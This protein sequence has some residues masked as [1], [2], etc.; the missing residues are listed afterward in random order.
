MR[1]ISVRG[2]SEHNLKHIDLDIPH[3]SLSVI[4]GL[5][6][7]GK[8]SLAFDTIF[9]EGQRRYVESLSAYARQFLGQM[10]RPHV[11]H[12]EGLAPAAAIDQRAISRNS[13]S[14]VGTITE[15]SD[16]LRLL[17]ARIGHVHCHRCGTPIEPQIADNIVDRILEL[18]HG[19][20]ATVL[21]PV[22]RHRKGEHREL[23]ARLRSTGYVRARIDGEMQ[24]LELAPQLARTK[25]HDIEVAVDRVKIGTSTRER[26]TDSVETALGLA[27]GLLIVATEEGDHLFSSSFGCP[28]CGASVEPPEPA[29]FS[30]NSRRGGCPNCKGLGRVLDF[31]PDNLIRDRRLSIREGAISLTNKSGYTLYAQMPMT[32]WKQ[33]G[34][35]FNFDIDIPWAELSEESRELIL[36]GA[37]RK[38]FTET[39]TWSEDDGASQGTRTQ[40]RR[41]QGLI[42]LL[43][44]RGKSGDGLAEWVEDLMSNQVCPDCN[45]ARLREEALA[46]TFNDKSI[47]EVT[48]LSIAAARDFM[49]GSVMSEREAIIATQIRREIDL[50][51]EFLEKV[52]LGYLTLGRGADTLAGGEAQRIRLAAQI[53]SGLEGV[54][55]V[56][57]EPSIGLH[58]RDNAGLLRTLRALRD[59]GNTVIVVEHDE[60]TIRQADH[61]VEIGPG[62]GGAGGEVVSSGTPARVARS[63]SPTGKYLRGEEQ[64]AIPRRRRRGSGEKLRVIGARTHNLQEINVTIPLG[65]LTLV[66]GVSGSGKSS[67]VN[68]ILKRAL[69][70]ELHNAKQK[71]GPHDRIEGIESIDKVIEIDQGPI[72]RNPRSNPATYS[73]V[74]SHIRDLFQR[75]PE[76]RARGYR[77]GRFSFNVKGGRC[78][79]CAG[80]GARIVEMQFM[81][82]VEVSC[83]VCSGD[84]FNRETLKVR[85]KERNIADVLALRIYEA[86]DFF[87]SIPTIRRILQTM[88]DVGL[89]YLALGQSSTTLSGGEAQRLKLSA[90]LAR[91]G[92][93]R[94]LYI[95]DEPTTGLHFADVRRL[96]DVLQRL[97]DAGNTVVVVEHNPDV[98]KVA[99][100]IVDLGPEGGDGGGRLVAAGRPEKIAKTPDSLT[101]QMLA[102]ILNGEPLKTNTRSRRSRRN[103]QVG[104][105]FLQIKGATKH[106]LKGVDVSIPKNALTV[107]TGVSGSGKST[108]AM[109]TLFSEGQ[110]RFVECLSSYARQFLGRFEDANVESISGLAPAIAIS[111]ENA[112][113]TPRSLVA[114]TTEVQDY[115]RVLY[116]RAGRPHCPNGHGPIEGMTSSEIV[117][118]IAGLGDG[119]RVQLIARVDSP[120]YPD[121][122]D[123][124]RQLLREGFLRVRVEGQVH[125]LSDEL[126]DLD[127]V[128]SD[129]VEI[130]VDRLLL[131]PDQYD[132]L[133][134]SVELVLARTGGLLIAEEV[135]AD[136]QVL[137][138]HVYNTGPVCGVCGESL[139]GL[140][141]PRHFSFNSYLGACPECTGLGTH[142]QFEPELV[143][144][145]RS[146]SYAEGALAFLDSDPVDSWWGRWITALADHYHFD[147]YASWGQLSPEVEQAILF[148]SGDQ[149]IER[150]YERYDESSSVSSTRSEPWEGFIPIFWRW[151][152]RTRNPAKHDFFERFMRERSCD[153]CNGERLEP[154][155]GAVRFAGLT[156]PD[157]MRLTV[158]GALQHFRNILADPD[159]AQLRQDETEI[160]RPAL[161]EI[162]N[163]LE[164]LEE[165]GVGYL[166]LDRRTATLSGGEAQRIRLA[167]Q[168]GTRLVGALYVLDE[169]S[170]GLHQR[171]ISRLLASLDRLRDLGNTLIVVEHDETT[172]RHADHLIDL[173]PGAGELGGEVVAQG[174]LEDITAAERSVT[175]QVLRSPGIV[176][177]VKMIPRSPQG[178]LNLRGVRE[179]NL[180]NMNVEI[181]LGSFTAVTGVSGSGKSTLIDDILKRALRRTIHGAMEFPGDFDGLDGVEQIDKVV[182]VDQSPIGRTAR[183]TPATY[184][185]VFDPIRALM[186]RLPESRV[187]GFGIRRFSFNEGP[188]KCTTC[189]G[190]GYQRIS[191]QF[192]ADVEVLCEVCQGRR[193][194]SQTLRV[195]YAGKNIA[196]ILEMTV[197]EAVEHFKNVPRVRRHLDVLR[198]VGLGYIR[199]GQSS[200]TLSGGEAQRIKFAA[201]LCRP[202]TGSTIYLLDEPTVGLHPT[203]VRL[204]LEVLNRLIEAGNTVVVIE[205]DLSVIAQA[206]HVIDLGPEGGEAG[207]AVVVTGTPASVARCPDS[208]TGRYLQQQIERITADA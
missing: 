93:G 20:V 23:I 65:T 60:M 11:D 138:T 101:G 48:A 62:A 167:T 102:P 147:P 121:A 51:L 2:A 95:L 156:L 4:T 158:T 127:A 73:G 45:G 184:T 146:L 77:P 7:S 14:T 61:V 47:A 120:N 54:L 68:D 36:F 198:D 55:Y 19:I 74:F 178:F 71:P 119:N 191:M 69:A 53:G 168:V 194:N 104:D 70:V 137:A 90:E 38:T 182:V 134:D 126:P 172:M 91:P 113:R 180:K 79:A 181:P 37:G 85:Y 128:E 5:S 94:T 159:L 31:D 155:I 163:R 152:E 52:G 30:F 57:D 84:R 6:G 76:A 106:N 15:I 151:Y 98:I 199:L 3:D 190:E 139:N 187:M 201:E 203:D 166:T 150:T 43:R 197:D 148:G 179:H 34:R 125:D 50:R 49:K 33:L 64:I 196:E 208:H 25:W 22:V 21:A 59:R 39:V 144:P 112:A 16:Y 114:T 185:G 13:R 46:I 63:D 149:P 29:L 164:F 141:T 175:G 92:T 200:R 78:E 75:L 9:K 171:D 193:Y 111:Q 35:A 118:A 58:H 135:G 96:I 27:D 105:G 67:L 192:L 162:C 202:A 131:G 81:G 122:A 204:L 183:S 132:R 66:T 207:G 117:T 143:V 189:R 103:G 110:R 165:V 130:I 8:S 12:I 157:V 108:L 26:V 100:W 133:G 32:S 1:K 154:M 177:R 124:F 99:D 89:G 10:E 115:L 206:D 174:T 186:S 87:D 129:E 145:D 116:A 88:V 17:F 109:D 56:L 18:P 42:P 136:G 161:N 123:L 205:H 188:G 82:D 44:R 160:A 80:R 140:L 41:W 173:G 107:M 24:R 170:V 176:Q 142:K 153:V 169:P 86:L 83:E 28:Q 97:V 72:G 195:R 40:R